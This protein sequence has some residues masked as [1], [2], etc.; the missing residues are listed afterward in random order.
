[1]QVAYLLRI[2]KTVHTSSGY[3]THSSHEATI[4]LNNWLQ[5]AYITNGFILRGN[6]GGGVTEAAPN[7]EPVKSAVFLNP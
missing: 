7:L 4:A 5:T 2:T 6:R 3:L 1:M